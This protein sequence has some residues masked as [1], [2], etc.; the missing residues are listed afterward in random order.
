MRTTMTFVAGEVE[1]VIPSKI[2]YFRVLNNTG[3]I[4]RPLFHRQQVIVFF[5]FCV[6]LVELDEL[7]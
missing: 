2:I 7:D 1:E 5:L 6:T 4:I 3:L